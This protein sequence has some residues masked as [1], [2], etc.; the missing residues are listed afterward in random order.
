MYIGVPNEK[1]ICVSDPP[2]A[3][4]C[5]RRRDGLRD[6]EVG[7]H[8]GPARQQ[9]VVG[10]DVAVHDSAL[11]RVRE[12]GG[13]VA[14]DVHTLGDRHRRARVLIMSRSDRPSTNG[15]VKNGTPSASPAVMHGDD[16]RVLQLR[17]ELDLAMEAIEAD[18]AGE[19]GR[20]Q[21]DHDLTIEPSLGGEKDVT[22]ASAAELALDGVG[23]AECGLEAGREGRSWAGRV[24]RHRLNDR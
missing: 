2:G 7:D 13:D 17:D 16:V 4:R 12:G 19:I 21:L 22:H 11:V 3:V 8:R 23:V 6:A 5:R 15:M 1:P 20:E 10:L 24:V 18:A 9:H 14:Q